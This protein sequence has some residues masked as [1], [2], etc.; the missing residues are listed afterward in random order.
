MANHRSRAEKQEIDRILF[1]LDAP[2]DIIHGADQAGICLDED[3]LPLRVQR[4]TFVRNANR[5]LPVSGR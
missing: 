2:A 1:A 5:R 4:L 3:V